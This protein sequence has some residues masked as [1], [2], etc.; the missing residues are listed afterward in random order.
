MQ[1]L[2]RSIVTVVASGAVVA[3]GLAGGSPDPMPVEPQ[4]VTGG[5]FPQPDGPLVI[6]DTAS[7]NLML[8]DVLLEFRR[9]TGQNIVMSSMTSDQVKQTAVGLLGGVTIPPTEV[10]SFMESLL[11]RHN[12]VV[13]ELRHNNPPLL[14]VYAPNSNDQGISNWIEVAVEDIEKYEDHHALL[15]QTVVDVSPLDGRQATSSMRTLA[16]NSYRQRMIAISSNSVI[17]YG[18]G[19][20]VAGWVSMLKKAATTEQAIQ[21]AQPEEPTVIQPGQ[22]R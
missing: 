18:T 11:A 15:V 7:G 1:F 6:P 8:V 20:E 14:A 13:S 12:F 2:S 5:H 10:Y 21:D 22:G 17:L 3:A 19:S 9:I 4:E 16:Q